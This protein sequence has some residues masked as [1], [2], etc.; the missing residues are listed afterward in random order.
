MSLFAFLLAAV[1]SA[2]TPGP[3]DVVRFTGWHSKVG[4]KKA[5]EIVDAAKSA[6]AKSGVSPVVL[7]GV[8]ANESDFRWWLRRGLDCGLMQIRVAGWKNREAAC[9]RF[10]KSVSRAMDRAAKVFVGAQ[11]HCQWADT[12]TE[13]VICSLVVYNQ[14]PKGSWRVRRCLRD[15]RKCGASTM[16]WARVACFSSYLADKTPDRRECRRIR[17]GKRINR[18][19]ALAK[20]VFGGENET[21][22]NPGDDGSLCQAKGG[23][24]RQSGH[25][26]RRGAS[27]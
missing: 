3:D 8:A 2:G 23:A 15:H 11:K 13:R 17:S 14:G 4:R 18:W 12:K 16:Y 1:L 27:D 7:L 19:L 21:D 5:V 26:R 25:G 24:V 9:R 20:S 22:H 6:G 10:M